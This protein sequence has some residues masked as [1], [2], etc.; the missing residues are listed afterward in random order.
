MLEIASKI[1]SDAIGAWDLRPT[2]LDS[3]AGRHPDNLS[4]SYPGRNSVRSRAGSPV[5][6]GADR[7]AASALR[8]GLSI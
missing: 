8:T 1:L 5:S 3:I 6:Q 2:S 7:A 4:S